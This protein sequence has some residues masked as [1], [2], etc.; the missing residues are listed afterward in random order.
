MYGHHSKIKCDALTE[1][2]L[3]CDEAVDLVGL[4]VKIS[5]MNWPEI[6]VAVEKQPGFIFLCS[7]FVSCLCRLPPG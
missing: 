5:W 3:H 2:M 4:H 6:S 7:C 1:L